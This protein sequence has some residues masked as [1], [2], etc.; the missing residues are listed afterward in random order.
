MTLH[1]FSS[2]IFHLLSS[3]LRPELGRTR[4]GVVIQQF[5]EVPEFITSVDRSIN[6][7]RSGESG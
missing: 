2:L 3:F 7:I 1:T 4:R 5:H 6:T